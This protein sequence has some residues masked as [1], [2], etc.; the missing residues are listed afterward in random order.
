MSRRHVS[1]HDEADGIVL[2]CKAYPE[3]DLRLQAADTL[4]R[5]LT[6]HL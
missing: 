2:A 4:A 3:S 5:C 1:E 6:R